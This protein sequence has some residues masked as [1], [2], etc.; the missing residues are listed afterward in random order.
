VNGRPRVSRAGPR[1]AT[2][3]VIVFPHFVL[4]CFLSLLALLPGLTRTL[5]LP[6]PFT[7]SLS[8]WERELVS[9]LGPPLELTPCRLSVFA[10]S[11][12]LILQLLQSVA[13]H[14]TQFLQP[15]RNLQCPVG[16]KLK[17]GPLISSQTVLAPRGVICLRS[18]VKDMELPNHRLV[19]D[20]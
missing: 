8:L 17:S 16:V 10:S 19:Y 18:C 20:R 11:R 1:S 13:F 3:R 15:I 7:P 9:E 12:C 6:L 2:G 14:A 5:F 4:S